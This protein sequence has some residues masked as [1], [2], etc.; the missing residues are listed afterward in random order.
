MGRIL[1]PTPPKLRKVRPTCSACQGTGF[2]LRAKIDKSKVIKSK[3]V[4]VSQEFRFNPF[5][6]VIFIFTLSSLYLLYKLV[7]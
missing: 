4:M 1:P 6:Y 3:P 7:C 2:R 5:N